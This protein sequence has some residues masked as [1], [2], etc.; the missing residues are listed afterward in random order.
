MFS[1][2]VQVGIPETQDT[3]QNLSWTLEWDV[4]KDIDLE[5]TLVWNF[6]GAPQADEDGT[7]PKK[8]D[9]RLIFGFGWEF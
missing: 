5:F 8:G 7:V 6:V 4:W 2:D 1:Y 9:L 3:N